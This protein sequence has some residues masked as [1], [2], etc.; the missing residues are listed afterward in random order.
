LAVVIDVKTNFRRRIREYCH[1]ND[2]RISNMII[3]KDRVAST[4]A[5]SKVLKGMPVKLVSEMPEIKKEYRRS[6]PTK[7][8]VPV[9]DCNMNE[10]SV[11]I[12]DVKYYIEINRWEVV[13][14]HKH[15]HLESYAKLHGIT[16]YTIKTANIKKLPDTSVN[17]SDLVDNQFQD[18]ITDLLIKMREEAEEAI[19]ILDAGKLAPL[20]MAKVWFDKKT[21]NEVSMINSY[22]IMSYGRLRR[23][24]VVMK[25]NEK[26]LSLYDDLCYSGKT[27]HKDFVIN[28][29]T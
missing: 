12:D 1:E 25:E 23:P 9:Y 29:L 10:S 21:P 17:L 7:K 3:I 20:K 16:Y 4:K 18:P 6:T 22:K 5:W 2:V 27:R 8:S 14:R 19:G 28:L 15:D 24:S 11:D 26:V 13:S